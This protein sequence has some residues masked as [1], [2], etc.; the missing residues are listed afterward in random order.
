M[1]EELDPIIDPILEKSFT[2][3]AGQKLI[4]LGDNE[5]EYN[6]KDFK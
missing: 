2:I 5:F 1:D 3:K 4:K 6:D